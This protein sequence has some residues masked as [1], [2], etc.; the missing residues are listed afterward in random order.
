MKNVKNTTIETIISFAAENWIKF[1][2]FVLEIGPG[3]GNLTSYILENN[4]KKLIL[5]LKN[6]HEKKATVSGSMLA[7][8]TET[9]ASIFVKAKNIRPR[10]R[11]F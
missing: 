4:P 7:I 10:Y 8:I 9:L 2:K 5:A 6:I 1:D 11:P 3:T